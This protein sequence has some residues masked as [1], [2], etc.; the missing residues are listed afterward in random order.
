MKS[1]ILTRVCVNEENEFELNVNVSLML[2]I[3]KCDV[4]RLS[5]DIRIKL[6]KLLSCVQKFSFCEGTTE[7]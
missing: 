5:H 3:T 2:G 4:S 1:C 6:D 7:K